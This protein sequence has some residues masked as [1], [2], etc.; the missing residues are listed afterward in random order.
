METDGH[1][2]IK[3]ERDVILE[4]LGKNVKKIAMDPAVQ[5]TAA[6]IGIAGGTALATHAI[7]N[8]VNE[9]KNNVRDMETKQVLRKQQAMIDEISSRNDALQE[10]NERLIDIN[11]ALYEAANDR[12]HLGG[13]ADAV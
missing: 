2:G 5:K 7:D 11:A 8:A 1:Y 6:C 3:T 12:A 10:K 4:L 13:D 9:N